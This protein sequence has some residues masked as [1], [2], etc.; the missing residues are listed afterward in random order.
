MNAARQKVERQGCRVCGAPPSQCDAAHTWDRGLDTSDFS[1]PDKIVP[2]CSQI[3]GGS[4]CHDRYDAH[5]LDLLPYMTTEE[6][7][8]MVRSAGSISR[9]YRRASG[10]SV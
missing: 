9:A 8:A 7:V 4:G 2:L 1:D 5:E 3:K 10:P 6:Q